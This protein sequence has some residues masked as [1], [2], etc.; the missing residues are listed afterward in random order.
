[1]TL[2]EIL[3]RGLAYSPACHVDA[4]DHGQRIVDAVLASLAHLAVEA[5]DGT[6][7]IVVDR[8]GVMAL[9]EVGREVAEAMAHHGNELFRLHGPG[10]Q[11]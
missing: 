6:A 2:A 11:S 9:A 3:N 1:M 8:A 7:E 10:V 4:I 5:T